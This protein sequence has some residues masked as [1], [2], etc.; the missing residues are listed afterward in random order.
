M[1]PST[2]SRRSVLRSAVAGLLATGCGSRSKRPIEGGYVDGGGARGHA[3]RDGTLAAG[4]WRDE[5]RRVVIVG[6]GVAGLS[7]A[8][9][10]ARAGVDDIVLLELGSEVGGTSRGGVVG[11][12]RCPWGAHYLPLPRVEQRA[13]AAFLGDA[14]IAVGAGDD[15]RVRVPDRLLV[16]DPEER[17][18]GLGF[19]EEGLW[20]RAGASD[21]D[22]A[23]VE[24]FEAEVDGLLRLGR[25]GRR[26]FD[27]PVAHSS[28]ELQDLDRTSAAAWCD[29]RGYT[30]DRIRWYLEYAA[31][32]DFGAALED[33]SAWALL[34][35]FASRPDPATGASAPFLAWP[36]GNAELVRAL[37]RSAPEVEIRSGEIATRVEAGPNGAVVTSV[38][39]DRR[40]TTRWTADAVIVATPQFVTR[41]LLA[42]DPARDARA[43]FRY[44]PWVV[45]N[46]HLEKRPME[47][48]FPAAWDSVLHGSESLGYVDATHQLDRSDARDA[49]W[50]WY[51]PLVDRDES[52]ARQRLLATP[53]EAMRDAVLDD[54]RGVHPDIDEVVTRIDVV[55]YGHAMVK[56]TPGTLFGGGRALAQEPIGAVHFAHSDLSG[57]A[58]FEEAHWQGTRAAEEVLARLSIDH[59]PLA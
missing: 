29:A 31:R 26:L 3:F 25:D 21:D 18:A 33:T 19:F 44:S 28:T 14:G 52:A 10:L 34:H 13:L 22:H 56:P 54:L 36:D 7:T 42:E 20:L 12:L 16:R 8:W 50:T 40:E 5:R 41:R 55:R 48:G 43:A 24:R 59:E 37:V 6:G 57:M 11:G 39:P 46:L 49:V 51:L 58:L 45:A 30:A 1:R 17:V 38:A 9:R 47:R 15:G 35:Y 32:D 27:L 2:L 53:W 4:G 23:D